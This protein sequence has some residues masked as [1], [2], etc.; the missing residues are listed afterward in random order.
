VTITVPAGVKALPPSTEPEPGE[1]EIEKSKFCCGGAELSFIWY[2]MDWLSL[3]G[4]LSA[5]ALTDTWIVCEPA[6][7]F[8]AIHIKS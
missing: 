4:L 8:S 3:A 7:D 6:S 5:I 2:G 1:T